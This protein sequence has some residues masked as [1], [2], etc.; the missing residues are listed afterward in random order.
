MLDDQFNDFAYQVFAGRI[1]AIPD[2]RLGWDAGVEA[3]RERIRAIAKIAAEKTWRDGDWYVGPQHNMI[4]K[5]ID[6]LLE[7]GDE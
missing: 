1:F 4:E 6:A 2:A 5:F 7:D 3:E